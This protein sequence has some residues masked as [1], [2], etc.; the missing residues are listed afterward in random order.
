MNINCKN[1]GWIT[2]WRHSV[3]LER[4]VWLAHNV[5][6]LVVLVEPREATSFVKEQERIFHPLDEFLIK[7][8]YGHCA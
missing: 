8:L 5:N 6:F 7:C 3:C 2:K 1:S 4:H